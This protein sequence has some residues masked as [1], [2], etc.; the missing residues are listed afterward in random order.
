MV[1]PVH[2]SVAVKEHQKGFIHSPIITE[3]KEKE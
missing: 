2:D 1:S 3:D